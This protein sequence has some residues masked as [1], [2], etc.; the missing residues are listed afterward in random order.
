MYAVVTNISRDFDLGSLMHIEFL[1]V[2]TKEE[3]EKL[4]PLTERLRL[5]KGELAS[6]EKE[7]LK[8]LTKKKAL[9][10]EIAYKR[11]RL[12]K[13]L[14]PSKTEAIQEIN[15]LRV[16]QQDISYFLNEGKPFSEWEKKIIEEEG[17]YDYSVKGKHMDTY[18]P[19]APGN[20]GIPEEDK[21]LFI[22]TCILILNPAYVIDWDIL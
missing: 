9:Y 22:K 12:F 8:P 6:K 11:Y 13:S 3:Q 2:D 21:W 5:L 18:L 4:Y 15:K 20:L 19:F 14:N 10:S 16:F 7:L 17:E 1:L